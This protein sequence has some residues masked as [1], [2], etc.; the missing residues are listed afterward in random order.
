MI[1]VMGLIA[2]NP[3]PLGGV[4][5]GIGA[6]GGPKGQEGAVNLFQKV[7]ST[8]IGVMTVVAGIWFIFILFTG[9]FAVINSGGDEG[10]L[11]AARGRITTGIIGL[12]VVIGGVFLVSLVGGLFG[13]SILNPAEFILGIWG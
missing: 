2:Q 7:I 9:A 8:T 5:S 11:K 3:Q 12:A 6:L 1:N 4:F 10:K 13:L